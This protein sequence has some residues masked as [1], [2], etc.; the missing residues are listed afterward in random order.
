M[1]WALTTMYALMNYQVTLMNEC[2]I[3]HITAIWPLTSMY[4]LMNY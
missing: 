2:L 1:I 3:A 4:V